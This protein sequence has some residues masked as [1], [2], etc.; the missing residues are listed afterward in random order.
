MMFGVLTCKILFLKIYF[1]YTLPNFTDRTPTDDRENSDSTPCLQKVL[2]V[3][4]G[5]LKKFPPFLK[6]LTHFLKSLPNALVHFVLILER[7]YF[8]HLSCLCQWSGKYPPF[9]PVTPE[10]P[11]YPSP[12]PVQ[13]STDSRLACS[14][15][16]FLCP[17]PPNHI[18]V[19]LFSAT[20]FVLGGGSPSILASNP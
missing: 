18:R 5:V 3:K 1:S 14:D 4:I 12:V 9:P 6:K 16:A 11:E 7:A 10:Y 17:L 15:V 19:F 8:S 20:C 13:C 2:F